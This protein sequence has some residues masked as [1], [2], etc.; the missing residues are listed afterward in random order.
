MT[1]MRC[2]QSS[3]NLYHTRIEVRSFLQL[4]WVE[5]D[6]ANCDD[7]QEADQHGTE[8]SESDDLS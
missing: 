5:A 3:L 4:A 7:V 8:A 1:K 2:K 6:T